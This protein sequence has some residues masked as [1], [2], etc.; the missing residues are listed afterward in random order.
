MQKSIRIIGFLFILLFAGYNAFA[1]GFQK[2]MHNYFEDDFFCNEYYIATKDG[3]VLTMFSK[4]SGHYSY[5]DAVKLDKYGNILWRK[6][7]FKNDQVFIG[8][9]ITTFVNY[10]GFAIYRLIELHNGKIAIFHSGPTIGTVCNIGV[11]CQSFSR[12]LSKLTVITIID[13]DG[14][15]ENTKYNFQDTTV[16]NGYYSEHLSSTVYLDSLNNRYVSYIQYDS[17]VLVSLY[18]Y[19]HNLMVRKNIYDTSFNLLSVTNF[20]IDT[21]TTNTGGG[22]IPFQIEK[23]GQYLFYAYRMYGGLTK[24]YCFV[25]DLSGVKKFN[26]PAVFQ[27]NDIVDSVRLMYPACDVQANEGFYYSDFFFDKNEHLHLFGLL[28]TDAYSSD[29]SCQ[30]QHTILIHTELE[31]SGNIIKKS[32]LELT[33][34]FNMWNDN[35]VGFRCSYFGNVMAFPGTNG[36]YNLLVHTIIGYPFKDYYYFKYDANQNKITSHKYFINNGELNRS[37]WYYG[38]YPLAKQK[39]LVDDNYYCSMSGDYNNTRGFE[40][41]FRI[42]TLGN[43][44]NHFIQGNVFADQNGNCIKNGTDKNLPQIT[45]TATGNNY[46]TFTSSDNNGNY[47]IG[48]GDSG[49]YLVNARTNINYPLFTQGNC[50]Q[51][52]SYSYLDSFT[53]DTVNL[54]LKPTILCPNMYVDISAP[55]LRRCF[56]NTYTVNYKNNGTIASPDTY[57]DITLDRFLTVNSASRPYT[58]LGNNVLRFQLGNVDYLSSGSFRIDVTVNCDST[59]IGQTHCATAH[60]YPD[61]VCAVSSYTGPVISAT[62]KCKVDSVE[63]KL[64][65]TGGNMPTIKRYIVIEDN[66]NRINGNYQ[67][68]ANQEKIVTI[69]ADSGHTYGII[70]EQDAAFPPQLGDLFASAFIEGCNA[71]NGNFTT[72]II[73]QYPEF[74][75]QPYASTDCQQNIGSYDPNDKTGYPIGVSGNHT[76][77]KNTALDY[78]INFQNTGTDT[79]FRV[80]IVDTISKYLNINTI[81]PGA[82]S[83]RYT[84][85]RTDSNVI[86]FIFDSINLV[87]SNKNER[88]SHGFVKFRI[89]QK[90]NN[91]NGTKIYNEAQIYFDY[92]SPIFTN[93]TMHTIGEIYVRILS[94]VIRPN[95]QNASIKVYPNP[96]RENAIIE[97]QNLPVQKTTLSLIDI[98]GKEMMRLQS[99]IN[100]YQIDGRALEKGMYLFKITNEH[101]EIAEGKLIVQ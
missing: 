14:N 67:L 28:L 68:N 54:A 87:D 78:H 11:N 27:F 72:G 12:N 99:D 59:V 17:T 69:A 83:H 35:C 86:K 100:Q 53:V 101:E 88:L 39:S 23:Y 92:N 1:G 85:M 3:N 71:T 4:N 43:I 60:I 21:L 31:N 55:F 90:P 91:A 33:E 62:A 38:Q 7:L 75:G 36:N 16:I 29:S 73:T 42:D 22:F 13:R 18:T 96:F 95:F 41:I 97:L 45:V 24:E 50:A 40:G 64:R 89:Q 80:V 84:Y 8:D 52:T 63:F 44:N 37:Y 65:N 9:S 81:E 70:A 32:F 93:R 20:L 25:T 82:S 66:L 15:V 48:I 98:T 77:E 2:N 6:K 76:I 5:S 58:N 51:G 46:S 61:T 47:Q 10:D 57:V 49:T 30:K 74:D 94:S 26:N 34:Q 56:S 19:R 79:A